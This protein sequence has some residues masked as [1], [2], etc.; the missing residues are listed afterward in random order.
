L[1]PELVA[2]LLDNA[3]RYT[4]R[5]GYIRRRDVNVE[6]G[7]ALLEIEDRGI[8]I[9]A[10]ERERVFAPFYRASRAH[11]I[12]P[13]GAGPGLSILHDIAALHAAQIELAD[14]R[15]HGLSVSVLFPAPH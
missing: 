13:N 2:S 7:A 5:D 15:G 11:E 9:A 10:A 14:A 6:H 3:L 12:N 1:L 4:P 8:G